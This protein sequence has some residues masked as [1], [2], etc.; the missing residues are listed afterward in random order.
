MLAGHETTSTALSWA[1][2]ALSQRPDIQTALREELR[3]LPLPRAASGCEPLDQETLAALDK[4]PLL[5][6]VVR[7]TLRLYA[8]VAFTSRAAT[9]DTTV[10]LARPFVD[11]QGITRDSIFL[12]RGVMIMT[13][14]SLVNRSKELWGPDAAEWK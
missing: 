5:D 14:I 8:P 7:E 10:P 2:Y 9:E 13:P 12:P 3:T 11:A 6:A 1:V 4:L